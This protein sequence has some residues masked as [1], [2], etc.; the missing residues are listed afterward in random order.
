MTDEPDIESASPSTEEPVASEEASAP[1]EE[2][3]ASPSE[4]LPPEDSYVPAVDP[5]P[6]N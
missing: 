6:E 5:E 3:T 2:P 4:D 1:P